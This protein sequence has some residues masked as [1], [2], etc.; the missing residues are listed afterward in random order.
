MIKNQAKLQLNLL[1][2]SPREQSR[3][4]RSTVRVMMLFPSMAHLLPS[5]LPYP[6]AGH[7]GARPEQ[8]IFLDTKRLFKMCH[9]A[10]WLGK[11]CLHLQGETQAATGTCEPGPGQWVGDW[12][13]LDLCFDSSSFCCLQSLFAGRQRNYGLSLEISDCRLENKP[14]MPCLLR[15][16]GRIDSDFCYDAS[17]RRQSSKCLA[18]VSQKHGRLQQ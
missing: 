14:K 15:W 11:D 17:T 1:P 4:A 7:H 9:P 5:F 18:A 16:I 12:V 3:D 6:V 2:V 8:L 13:K 10:L